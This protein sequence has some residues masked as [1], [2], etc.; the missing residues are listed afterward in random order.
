[1]DC[2]KKKETGGFLYIDPFMT[3]TIAKEEHVYVIPY[4]NVEAIESIL[5]CLWLSPPL[6]SD[7]LK[8]SHCQTH[9]S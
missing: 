8:V 6:L 3:E 9:I 1:M 7:L 4:R 5:N 2:K